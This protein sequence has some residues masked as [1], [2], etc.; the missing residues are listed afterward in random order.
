MFLVFILKQTV[1]DFTKKTHKKFSRVSINL[2]RNKNKKKNREL[3]ICQENWQNKN[4]I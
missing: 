4:D 2:S 1:H 3:F